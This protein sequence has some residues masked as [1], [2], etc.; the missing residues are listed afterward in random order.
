MKKIWE[1]IQ[2][3]WLYIS[4]PLILLIVLNIRSCKW[5]K[6]FDYKYMGGKEIN[7]FALKQI[8]MKRGKDLISILAIDSNQ[9]YQLFKE[10]KIFDRLDNPN[11]RL[12]KELMH[13][14]FK[15]FKTN[16]P[17]LFDSL[18]IN[19]NIISSK[20]DPIKKDNYELRVLTRAKWVFDSADYQIFLKKIN[21]NVH[22]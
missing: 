20:L 6:T 12:M 1:R 11:S 21:S 10:Y 4:A 16:Y 19:F 7:Q 22:H 2:E 3:R 18:V 8:N 5:Y 15:N 17:D 13:L 14:E 9:N